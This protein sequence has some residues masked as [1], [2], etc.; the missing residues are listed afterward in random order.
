MIEERPQRK[1]PDDL[2]QAIFRS[3][4]PT[5]QDRLTTSKRSK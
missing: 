2:A 3:V 4:D 5:L 1:T